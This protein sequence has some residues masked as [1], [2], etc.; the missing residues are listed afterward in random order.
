MKN[1]EDAAGKRQR[2]AHG[3]QTG[4]QE[5]GATGATGY[6][7]GDASEDAEACEDTQAQAGTETGTRVQ[8]GTAR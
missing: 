7:E 6:L 1:T 2:K 4:T 5:T 8:Q 3:Q